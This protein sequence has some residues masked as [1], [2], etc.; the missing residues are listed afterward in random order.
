[1]QRGGVPSSLARKERPLNTKV[2]HFYTCDINI[3]NSLNTHKTAQ[4][5]DENVM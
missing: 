2:K 5:E 4:L 1:M 3:R